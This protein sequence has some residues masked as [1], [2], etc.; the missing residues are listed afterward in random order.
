MYSKL[1]M[2]LVAVMSSSWMHVCSTHGKGT[3][4]SMLQTEIVSLLTY[5]YLRDTKRH[6]QF[7]S[8]YLLWPP[9]S[10]DRSHPTY[11]SHPFL[12]RHDP[13]DH[14]LESPIDRRADFRPLVEI[15]G[16]HSALADSFRRKLEFLF[17]L[18]SIRLTAIH[19]SLTQGQK[20]EGREH[21]WTKVK[22]QV[23]DIPHR[24]SCKHHWRRTD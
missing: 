4:Y 8:P 7:I 15:N 6:I 21:A 19:T 13:L 18:L 3:G 10:N 17:L 1:G 14:L 22:Y 9:T 5:V 20:V 12:S 11:P 16:R 2:V 24:P 23:R